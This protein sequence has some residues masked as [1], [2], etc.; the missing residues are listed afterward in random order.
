MYP[1][2][3]MSYYAAS[4]AIIGLISAS[5]I[6]RAD[7]LL[8][9]IGASPGSV[10]DYTPAG[11]LV[12]DF[13]TTSGGLNDPWNMTYGPDGNLYVASDLGGDIRAFDGATGAYLRTVASGLANPVDVKFDGA[14][15]IYVAE[16]GA[17]RIDKINPLTGALL[18]TY[19]SGVNGAYSIAFTSSGDLLATNYNSNNVIKIDPMTGGSTVFATGFTQP[20]GITVGL[21]GRY[22]VADSAG[23]IDVVGAAGGSASIWSS[24]QSLSAG[25]TFMAFDAGKLFVTVSNGVDYFDAATGQYTGFFSTGVGNTTGITVRPSVAGVP[26]TSTL[27]MLTFGVVTAAGSR[28]RRNRASSN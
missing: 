28:M 6:A 9:G 10:R 24:G 3:T 25:A 5:R 20:S 1:V 14:G 12:G 8:V 13:V 23:P 22:Y 21:D 17:N 19:T 27:A 18:Q 16:A 7:D 26:E 15:F 11:L 4:L 2:R